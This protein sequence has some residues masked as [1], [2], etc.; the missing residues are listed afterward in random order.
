[1]STICSICSRDAHIALAK[2]NLA[3]I[4]Q[5]FAFCHFSALL[6]FF[7]GLRACVPGRASAGKFQNLKLKTQVLQC[8][9]VNLHFL[10][11]FMKKEIF[12]D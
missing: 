10:L 8:G 1:M 3:A 5:I 2:M 9:P 6:T 4:S 7:G 12:V 11:F